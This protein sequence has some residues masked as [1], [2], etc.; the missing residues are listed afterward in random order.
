MKVRTVVALTGVWRSDIGIL[1]EATIVYAKLTSEM[2]TCI[3]CCTVRVA[4]VLFAMLP[5]LSRTKT[6][7]FVVWFSF[8]LSHGQAGSLS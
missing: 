2:R 1:T 4:V 6:L 7:P 8:I 5:L 3:A